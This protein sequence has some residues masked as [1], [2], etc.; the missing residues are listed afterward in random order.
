MVGQNEP[1]FF[2]AESASEPARLARVGGG[3]SHPRRSPANP[4]AAEDPPG[5]VAMC[6]PLLDLAHDGAFH[7]DLRE[8]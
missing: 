7:V 1:I 2:T 4:K 3:A 8:W 5:L 6:G